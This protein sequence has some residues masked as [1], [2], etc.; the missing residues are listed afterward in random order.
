M[1]HVRGVGSMAQ[2]TVISCLLLKGFHGAIGKLACADYVPLGIRPRRCLATFRPSRTHEEIIRPDI[3]FYE[4][5]PNA[6][7][8]GNNLCI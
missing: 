7:V 8:E 1:A 5:R 2:K 4:L 6:V 3:P